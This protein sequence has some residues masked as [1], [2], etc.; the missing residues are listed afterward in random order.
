MFVVVVV[1]CCFLFYF[2]ADLSKAVPLLPFIF[3][4]ASVVSHVAFVSSLFVPH[5]LFF[6]CLGKAGLRDCDIARVSSLIF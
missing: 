2:F 1:G 4:H 6:W 3:V 5:L